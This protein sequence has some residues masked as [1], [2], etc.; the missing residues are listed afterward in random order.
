MCDAQASDVGSPD[1]DA[2]SS[3]STGPKNISD[4]DATDKR[5]PSVLRPPSFRMEN[6]TYSSTQLMYMCSAMYS[7]LEVKRSGL[8]GVGSNVLHTLLFLVPFSSGRAG[9]P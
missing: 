5:K 6:M 1:L 2:E 7:K 4:L 3:E 8:N 9:E